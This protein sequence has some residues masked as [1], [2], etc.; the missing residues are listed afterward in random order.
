[1]SH[2]PPSDASPCEK[3]LPLFI[4]TS[5]MLQQGLFLFSCVVVVSP[6][7]IPQ[8]QQNQLLHHADGRPAA[9][10]LGA[11]LYLFPH[12]RSDVE[13]RLGLRAVGRSH[14][15]R[16]ARVGLLLIRMSSGICTVPG[17]G[18]VCGSV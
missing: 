8:L 7:A 10:C 5:S 16:H 13:V 2:R 1:M 17:G 11:S 12:A 14:H 15:H 3:G 4:L 9:A 18:R 6:S